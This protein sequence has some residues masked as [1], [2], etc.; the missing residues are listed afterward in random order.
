[1]HLYRRVTLEGLVMMGVKLSP[2]LDPIQP[3]VAQVEHAVEVVEHF[4]VVRY[5]Q[6]RRLLFPGDLA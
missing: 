1:M 2:A 6:D 4:F 5:H 3:P